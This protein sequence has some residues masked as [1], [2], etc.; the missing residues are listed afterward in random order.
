M[1]MSDKRSRLVM[2]SEGSGALAVLDE[3]AL[4]E[5]L[6]AAKAARVL[7]LLCSSSSY[8]CTLARSRVPVRL[9]VRNIRLA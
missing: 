5:V 4:V 1:A 7:G 6:R 8:L 3:T 2:P 9:E